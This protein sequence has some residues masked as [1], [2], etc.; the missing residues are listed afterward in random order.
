[1]KTFKN[2]TTKARFVKEAKMHQEADRFIQ[3]NWLNRQIGDYKSGCFYGCMTQT[4]ENTLSKACEVMHLP[5]WLVYVSEK[6][7]EG[8]PK[9]EA[10][11]FP[12]ELLEAIPVGMDSDKAYKSFMYQLLMDKDKGQINFTKK[13]SAQYKAIKQCSD[14]FLMDEITASAALS[15]ARSA[16]SAA[17]SAAWSAG[18]TAWSAASAAWSAESLNYYSWMKDLLIK[19]VKEN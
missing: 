13:G 2:K 6:I 5:E 8:L 7:F 10:I 12:L 19:I 1:M 17:R 9:E 18:I 4:K 14:L 3:G 11:K 15:A 16:E